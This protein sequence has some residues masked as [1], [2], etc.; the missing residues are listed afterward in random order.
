MP[1]DAPPEI[2]NAEKLSQ[3]RW[4][5]KKMISAA[6]HQAK[7]HGLSPDSPETRDFVYEARDAAVDIT[8]S[9]GGITYN[10]DRLMENEAK[11]AFRMTSDASAPHVLQ[12]VQ[13]NGP[14]KVDGDRLEAGVPTYLN[15]SI[16]D[17]AVDWMLMRCLTQMEITH[18]LHVQ[19]RV[20]VLTKRSIMQVMQISPGHRWFIN[21][22]RAF[23]ITLTLVAASVASAVYVPWVAPLAGIVAAALLAICFVCYTAFSGIV[24]MSHYKALAKPRED[25][26]K[27]MDEMIAFFSEFHDPE[28]VSIPHFRRRVEEL[29]ALGAVWPQALWAML[30]DIEARGI[31]RL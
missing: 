14:L 4:F 10:Y 20:D 18:F 6:I 7:K 2:Q 17:S 15:G 30:D 13:R 29:R 26:S 28:V 23:L 8:S 1:H 31:T 19:T 9:F 25:W 21:R 12:D 22:G 3:K 27:L 16:R 11:D 24:L 5:I